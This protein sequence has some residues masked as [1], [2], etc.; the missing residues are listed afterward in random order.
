MSSNK[1][2]KLILNNKKSKINYKKQYLIKAMK[3]KNKKHLK[4][5]F[6]NKIWIY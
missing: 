3:S 4:I 5:N 2:N 6:Q 1:Q